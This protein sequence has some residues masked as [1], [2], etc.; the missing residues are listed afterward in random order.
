[1]GKWFVVP[2]AASFL[3]L[4]DP[5]MSS[6]PGAKLLTM[7]LKVCLLTLS[8][9]D[10][11]LEKNL[12]IKWVV[13]QKQMEGIHPPKPDLCFLNLY[14]LIRM[15]LLLVSP[16]AKAACICISY[17]QPR[18]IRMGTLVAVLMFI[19]FFIWCGS[20]S[21]KLDKWSAKIVQCC[22][23]TH[24]ELSPFDVALAALS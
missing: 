10:V 4:E 19:D 13:L 5:S 6:A 14:I 20:Q 2:A 12:N 22:W 18:V 7:Y 17:I 1:M 8:L 23:C 11:F 15:L 21:I 24:T 16:L 9:Y 3:I